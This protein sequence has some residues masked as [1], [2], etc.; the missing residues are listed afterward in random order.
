[1][2][3][4]ISHSPTKEE[5]QSYRMQKNENETFINFKIDLG[6]LCAEQKEE[7]LTRYQLDKKVLLYKESLFLALPQQV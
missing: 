6:A 3:K 1:M 2:Y 7:L 5:I 4:I